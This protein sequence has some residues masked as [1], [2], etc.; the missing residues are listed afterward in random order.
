MSRNATVTRDGTL[1]LDGQIIRVTAGQTITGTLADVAVANNLAVFPP[2]DVE[3]QDGTGDPASHGRSTLEEIEAATTALD[4]AVSIA[5]PDD[6]LRIVRID[7]DG[8]DGAFARLRELFDGREH[9]VV[10][11][12]VPIA[13]LNEAELRHAYEHLAPAPEPDPS[14]AETGDDSNEPTPTERPPTSGAGSGVD[15]WRAYAAAVGVEVDTDASRDDIVAA[16]DAR[17][18]AGE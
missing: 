18:L 9:P 7:L 3:P 6:A 10:L 5:L 16:V 12:S 1:N 4:A 2:A 8:D 14:E 13:E 11:V 15:A 17:E